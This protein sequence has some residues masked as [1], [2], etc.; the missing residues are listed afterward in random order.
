MNTFENPEIMQMRGV[1][2]SPT[3]KSK[4]YKFELKQDISTELLSISFPYICH[5]HDPKLATLFLICFPMMFL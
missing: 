5:P 2:G 3:S 4:S 1:G